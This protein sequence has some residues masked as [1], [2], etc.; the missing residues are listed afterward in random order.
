M[1]R[2][3]L[4]VSLIIVTILSA[5]LIILAL[6]ISPITKNYI[7]KHSKDLI[8]RKIEMRGL[9]L[10]IFTGT[11]ELDSIALYEANDKDVFASIDTFFV[12]LKLS[13][14]WSKNLE[15]S[16]LKVIR[17]YLVIM[18]NDSVFNFSDIMNRKS[19][20]QKDKAKSEFP[21]S[22]V[23]KNIFMK[24]GR[25][26]YT[27]QQLKNTIKMNE[28]GVAIPEL[29]FGTGDTKGGVHL[30]VGDIATIDSKLEMN[31][32]TKEYKLNLHVKDLAI[33]IIKPYVQ[34]YFNIDEFEGVV[35][36][37]ILI[38]GQTDH[39]MG[40]HMN[41]TATGSNFKMTNSVG[42]PL[43]TAE[44]V[45]VKIDDISKAKALYLF[46]YIHASAATIDFIMNPDPKLNNFMA[47]FKPDDPTDTN[48]NIQKTLKIKDLHLTNSQLTFTDKS[49]K[50]TVRIPI[51]R[52]D[53]QASDFDLSGN[54]SFKMTGGFAGGGN[55]KFNWKGNRK[56]FSNQQ[57]FMNMQNFGLKQVSSYCKAY[58]AYDITSGN[59]NFETRTNIKNN[60]ITSNNIVDVYKMDV[61]KKHQEMKPKYNLPLKFALYIMKD[62]DEKINFNLPVKGNMK[63][64]KFSYSQIL[65]QTVGNLMIKVALSP[66]KFLASSLGM[67]PDKMESITINPLQTSFTAEQYSQLNDLASIIK[68][69]PELVLELT[70]FANLKD[71]LDDYALYKTKYSYLYSLSDTDKKNPYT[72]EEVQT[73]NDNDPDFTY[74]VDSLVSAKGK[75]ANTMDNKDKSL[76]LYTRDSLQN[77]LLSKFESRNTFL[78][79]YLKTS[80]EIQE[81]NMAIKNANNDTLKIFRDKAHYKI[82]MSLPGAN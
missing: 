46:N 2:K 28:L 62:K 71:V 72:F 81:K 13:K 61:G 57:I 10:N 50:P 63:D 58:T 4:K 79:N 21:K 82:N 66:V 36:G 48:S 33:N 5:I 42:E 60:D 14:L 47:I 68:R 64:P 49:L 15:L 74:Y 44:T 41:G 18:Q 73:V 45:N 80:F 8:G 53:F 70:Q 55:M 40:F 51:K 75:I 56:D 30:K 67:N 76:M 34:Q 23:I 24:G 31:M 39:I 7:Q 54:M 27:D 6:V 9:H 16:Q 52:I 37:D 29:S 32:K 3:I 69:K 26:I 25:L 12:D 38:A 20:T 1:K 22:I 17:P 19:S 78:K 65:W 35:G 43:I 77:E 11:L 59:M